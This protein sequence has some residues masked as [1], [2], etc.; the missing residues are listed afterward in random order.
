[1]TKQGDRIKETRIKAGLTQSELAKACG[2][3][4]RTAIA[5]IEA[6]KSEMPF[7]KLKLCAKALGTNDDYLSGDTD[8]DF[9]SPVQDALDKAYFEL[10]KFTFNTMVSKGSERI[11]T[12]WGELSPEDQTDLLNH[13]EFLL[14]GSEKDKKLV[15]ELRNGLI[16]KD[17]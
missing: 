2:Y 8:D 13:A 14:A 5:N 17:S 9:R 12:Y 7:P 6:G 3:K 11:V 1:M 4:S 16:E 15:R 10:R